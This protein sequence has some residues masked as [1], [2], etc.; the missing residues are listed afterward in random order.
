MQEEQDSLD[1]H[2]VME[3]VE[4]PRGHKVIPVHWIFSV[5]TDAHGNV[6]RFKARLVAQ[7]CRQIPGV[8]VDEVFA[9]TSS[10][11]SRRTLLATAAAK[12]MEIHQVDIKTAFLNGEL[13]EEVYVTQPP[14][15]DNGNPN[16]VC[17][18]H[19]ALYGL[20]QAPRAWHKTL[21]E[22]LLSMGYEV[23]KSDAGVYIKKHEDG[24]LSY[25]LVYV[26]DLLI[27]AMGAEEIEW[28]KKELLTSFK[29]HDLG[30][31]KDFL[32]C[33]IQRDRENRCLSISCVPKIDGL[34]EKFGV[35]A[36]SR[37]VDTPMS[38]DFVTTGMPQITVGETSFGS[39]TPLPP[40]HRYCELVG[41]LLYIANTTRPD[42]AQAVGVL[43]RYR[44]APTTAHMNEGLR[45]LRYLQSTR[46]C[47]LVLGGKGP[48]LE[49]HVDADYAGDIDSRHSTSGYVL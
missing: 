6:L 13:E 41:S 11:G 34:C 27:V 5:K 14:G 44:N 21:N 15:F 12:N 9:P 33:Q 19:K 43:S 38:K 42:I 29:I 35:S 30:E 3:Y 40:G 32:G 39:G 45:V 46:E 28:V 18:L 26:D 20:K 16:I 37:T 36:E 22:K 4:R 49:G 1:A 31:V 7:G 24:E 23:C 25:M 2:E 10:Y 8:D 17:R 48:V 47:V